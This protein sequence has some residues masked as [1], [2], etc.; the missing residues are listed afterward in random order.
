MCVCV[1][2]CRLFSLA[3]QQP[4]GA[5]PTTPS[6]RLGSQSSAQCGW[7]SHA[8]AASNLPTETHLF[9]LLFCVSTKLWPCLGWVFCELW[10]IG[11][12]LWS[13]WF[14]GRGIQVFPL[15]L[16]PLVGST[17]V[18]VGCAWVNTTCTCVLPA[19]TQGSSTGLWPLSHCLGKHTSSGFSSPISCPVAPGLPHSSLHIHSAERPAPFHSPFV[20]RQFAIVTVV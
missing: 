9:S 7:L 11:P 14:L 6:P 12:R 13:L 10:C 8:C 4:Q 19:A 5:F 17:A 18:S 20:C 16:P 1:H 15:A 2:V 3:G